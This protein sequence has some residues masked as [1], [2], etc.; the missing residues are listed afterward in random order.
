MFLLTRLPIDFSN[1]PFVIIRTASVVYSLQSVPITGGQ[2][3]AAPDRPIG[4]IAWAQ[5]ESIT[6]KLLRRLSE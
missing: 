5:L 2:A 3:M 6:Y 1:V 4:G